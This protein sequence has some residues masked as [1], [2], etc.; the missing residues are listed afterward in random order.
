MRA[1]YYPSHI[2]AQITVCVGSADRESKRNGSF[3]H[4][5][6][7]K[8]LGG[9]VVS[10]ILQIVGAFYAVPPE[11]R[12]KMSNQPVVSCLP[13]TAN[14]MSKAK[15]VLDEA[16]DTKNRE[17][18]LVD[19]NISTFD[20]LPGLLNMLFVTRITLSHNKLKTVPPGIANLNNLE[21]L[22][23]SNNFLEELPLSLSSMP[24]LR[25]LNCSINRLNTLPRGFGAFPVLEVLDLSYNN[26]NEHVLPGNFFMMDSLRALY[27]G[28]NEFEYLPKEIKNLKNLQILGLRDNDLLELPREIGELTRI[29]ELHIQNNRLS[30]LPPEI[31]NLDMPG[32]KSVLK[33]EENPWVTAIAEQYLVGISHV[34]EYIKTEAYRILYNRHMQSGGKS[35][36]EL[37]PKSDKSKKASRARS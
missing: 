6:G 22:N 14:K 28:D 32:P 12:A 26:L 23:L 25:I 15:K 3:I 4:K 33:M 31:A 7:S 5:T 37:P 19:R 18:D 17:I 20:E 16:R 24:K 11:F 21:I 13:V 10:S 2:S 29:R 27:L 35:A 9:C 1:H 34:L 8:R 30:V 36:G